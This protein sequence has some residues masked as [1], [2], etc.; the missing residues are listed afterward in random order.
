[1]HLNTG[2]F[3]TALASKTIACDSHGTSVMA[4]LVLLCMYGCD[5]FIIMAAV[6]ACLQFLERR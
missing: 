5:D 6:L 3:C 2:E 1:M 4:L